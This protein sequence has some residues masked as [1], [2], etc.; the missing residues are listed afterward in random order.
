MMAR[1]TTG[2]AKAKQV[3]AFCRLLLDAGTPIILGGWHRDVY[4]IWLQEL[5]PYKP[6]LYTGS[7]TVKEK[8]DVK[9]AFMRGDCD[10]IIM[11][12]RS[13]AGLDGLQHR[14]K[15]VVHGELDWS[16]KVH[17][18]LRGRLR[19]HARTDAIDEYYVIADGGSDPLI[20]NLHGLKASQAS[21]ILDPGRALQAVQTDESRLKMLAQ[22]YLDRGKS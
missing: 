10:C 22:M 2:V 12:L 6:R 4:D 18:Q 9:A 8:D 3:A 19:P 13:G 7:E 16:P 11:S 17:E 21:G 15:T 14:C 5:A 20:A 1:H